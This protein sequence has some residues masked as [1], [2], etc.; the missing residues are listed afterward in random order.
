VTF[1]TDKFVPA[2]WLSAATKAK[3]SSFPRV[4]ENTGVEILLL[5]EEISIE[6]VVSMAMLVDVVAVELNVTPV[7]LALLMVT[8][9]LVGVNV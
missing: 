5:L 4:V 2:P 6:M 9:R 1:E 7:I 8:V 3:S